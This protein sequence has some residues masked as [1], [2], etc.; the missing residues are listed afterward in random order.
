M[1]KN[2]PIIK[3]SV[4]KICVECEELNYLVDNLP[5]SV[6]NIKIII[7]V[8]TGRYY[9]DLQT[10][11]PP[12]SLK[13]PR[14]RWKKS[15]YN[16]LQTHEHLSKCSWVCFVH[17]VLAQNKCLYNNCCFFTYLFDVQL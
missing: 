11:N 9:A 7:K 10:D 8:Q 1:H 6:E 17:I 3:H 13:N 12:S 14:M 5:N 4:A 15:T 16:S 2:N